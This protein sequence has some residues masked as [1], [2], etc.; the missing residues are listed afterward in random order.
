[1]TEAMK[2]FTIMAEMLRR[3][4]PALMPSVSYRYCAFRQVDHRQLMW[5][6]APTERLGGSA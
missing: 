1:M 2:F 4:P 6:A 3:N 5:V